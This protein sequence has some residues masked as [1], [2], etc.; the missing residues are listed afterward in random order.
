MREKIPS[1]K[2]VKIFAVV[3]SVIDAHECS[4]EQ[5]DSF[6]RGG[7]FKGITEISYNQGGIRTIV[8]REQI[9]LTMQKLDSVLEKA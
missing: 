2:S 4:P 6:L 5:L 3:E 7:R 9:P 1:I 8:V